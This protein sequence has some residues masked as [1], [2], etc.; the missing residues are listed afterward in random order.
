MS[1]SLQ[2][3]RKELL[4]KGKFDL[5]EKES[6]DSPI[7]KDIKEA[8]YLRLVN[9]KKVLSLDSKTSF[10]VNN[11][12]V[13]LKLIVYS[14]INQGLST[15]EFISKAESDRIEILTFAQRNDLIRYLSGDSTTSEHLVK[16]DLSKKEEKDD[17]IKAD[18]LDPF[19]E[20]VLSHERNLLDH[21]TSLRGSKA[22]DFGSVGKECEIRIIKVLKRKQT[23][24]ESSSVDIKKKKRQN[25]IILI[26]PAASA[27]ITI[28]NVKPFLELSK[29][30]DPNSQNPEDQSLLNSNTDNIRNVTHVF[31]RIGKQSFLVVNNTDNFT[32]AEYWDRVVAIV[33][34]G[35][36]WQF[37]SYKWSNPK[38]LFQKIK[39][40]YFHYDKD[41][42][43]QQ[44]KE[45]NVQKVPIDKNR[46]FRDA[47][48]LNLF[49]DSIEKILVSKGW[50]N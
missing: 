5:L 24:P 9:A 35:Q 31:P 21:N 15:A 42:I 36:S 38:E 39:G 43:P 40:Y 47:E 37:K 41:L 25:P 7:V 48:S 3:L 23:A 17:K 45:W 20:A 27:L 32:K 11:L 49:W 34:T 18:E 26:S 13:T 19:L 29:F 1:D 28:S 14:W 44:I 8:K 10:I 22:I 6:Q 4:N 50:A 33:T 2:L 16:E 46:R 12:P 30:I